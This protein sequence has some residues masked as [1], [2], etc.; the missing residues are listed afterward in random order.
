[1]KNIGDEIQFG[2]YSTMHSP[3]PDRLPIILEEWEELAREKLEDGPYYYVAGGAGSGQTMED[4]LQAFKA[5]KIVQKMLNKVDERDLSVELFGKTYPYP[6]LQAPIGVQSIIHPEGEIGSA[7]ASAEVGVP[8]VASSASSVPMEKV[9]EEMGDA[10]KW[11]QLYWSKDPDI[12][13]SF[14]KRAEAAGYSAIVVTLDTPMMAWRERDLKH[15]YLPFLAGEGVGNYFSDP[16]FRAAL[17]ESPEENPLAAIMHWTTIF[18]NSALTWE[19][20]QF[21]KEHTSLPIILKGIVHPEDAKK[22]LEAK[23]DGIIVSNHGGRQVDGGIAALDALPEVCNVIQGEIPVLMDSGIRRGSD[24]IKAMALGADAVLV[25]RPLMYGL[26]LSGQ[27]G[28]KEVLNNLIAD[29]D[30][31]LGLAGERSVHEL[32]DNLLLKR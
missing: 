31:T 16:A 15:V 5:W 13:A 18:G 25:G 8:F 19:D 29:L 14:L 9:A 21:V 10:E 6:I 20:I 30:I 7:L 1:M 17:D 23:V 22:A 26:A 27:Q 4:N 24:I 2:I 11:F 12:T 28:V 32:K 3:D